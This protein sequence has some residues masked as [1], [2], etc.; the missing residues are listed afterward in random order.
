MT[1][2]EGEQRLR[3]RTALSE[4][5]PELTELI[6]RSARL[7][8]RGYYTEEETESAIR[9]VFGVDSALVADRTYFVVESGGV[10][11]GCGGWSRRRTLYG[12]DQRPVG[13]QELLNP[14]RDAARIR[15]F[16]VAPEAARQGVGRCLFDACVGAAAEAGFQ[17]VELMATLPGVP[18]YAALGCDA[19][20]HVTDT[21]PD[22]VALRFVRMRRQLSAPGENTYDRRARNGTIENRATKP[23][24]SCGPSAKNRLPRNRTPDVWS[25][26]EIVGHLIDSAANNHQ[27]FV[28]AQHVP[29]FEFPGY[30]QNLWMRS[31]DYQSCSWRELVDFWVLYNR[32]LAH[33]VRR[34]PAAA[35]DIPCRIGEDESVT[36]GFLIE[37]YVRHLRHPLS[38][39]AER[40]PDRQVAS[41]ARSAPS[42][43]AGENE[44]GHRRSGHGVRRGHIAS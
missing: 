33:V 19:V 2:H 29:R 18:F 21:L 40:R 30:E 25:V 39:I 31:Q 23:R 37:D 7:L 16:F 27:R 6:S 26:K 42:G 11:V 13:P 32:H 9:H 17:W 14:V 8:S 1:P 44:P 10:I 35:L 12:G 38:Q 41:G 20:E 5:V 24:R 28:R 22:G 34:V 4:D 15:A 43:D 3:L 36:L